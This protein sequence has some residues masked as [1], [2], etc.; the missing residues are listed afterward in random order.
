MVVE[1]VE[2]KGEGGMKKRELTG[3]YIKRKFE[4]RLSLDYGYIMKKP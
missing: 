4:L 3:S 2:A 1:V